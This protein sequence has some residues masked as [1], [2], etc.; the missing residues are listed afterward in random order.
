MKLRI[1]TRQ[2]STISLMA[3]LGAVV[4]VGV[5]WVA[6]T[7]PFFP[8]G[9]IVKIGLC[10]TLAFICGFS[11]GPLQGFITGAL[12]IVVSDVLTWAGPWTP[13]I[14]SII[15]LLGV[16]G[17]FLRRVRENP[18]VVFFGVTA[19]GLTLVSETLQNLYTTWFYLVSGMPLI[20]ALITAFSGGIISMVTA[21]LNNAVLFMTVAPRIIRII[22][23]W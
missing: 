11:F 22:R 8:Y 1:S 21:I 19:V 23:E 4:R 5:N 10:E 14:A 6:F 15:G 3:A 17:G 12:T 16:C 2:L 18:G 7:T 9:I 20:V 13:I